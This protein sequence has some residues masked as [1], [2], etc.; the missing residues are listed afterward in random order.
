MRKALALSLQAD[1]KVTLKAIMLIN[2]CFGSGFFCP[3]PDRTFFPE[4]RSAKKIRIHEKAAKS[5][6]I[7][8]STHTHF[9]VSLL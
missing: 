2:Q 9:F 4:S 6:T 5:K 8:F 3:D 7:F 1:S